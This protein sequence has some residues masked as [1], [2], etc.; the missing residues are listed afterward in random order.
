MAGVAEGTAL[1]RE[2]GRLREQVARLGIDLAE[3]IDQARALQRDV[4]ALE[5]ALVQRDERAALALA[6]LI[7]ARYAWLDNDRERL[8]ACI[9][10][11]LGVLEWEG[12]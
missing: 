5:Q 3:R 7:A 11:A 4:V 1:R 6:E 10:N 8:W 2:L 12:Q 9:Q